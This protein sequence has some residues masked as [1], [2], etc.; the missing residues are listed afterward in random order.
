MWRFD[1]EFQGLNDYGTDWKYL[2]KVSK[3]SHLRLT[4]TQFEESGNGDGA[5]K[6]HLLESQGTFSY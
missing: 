5:K 4:K 6:S 1:L 3:G 2:W